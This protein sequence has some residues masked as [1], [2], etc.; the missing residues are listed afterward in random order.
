[1][2]ITK[3][4]KA[5]GH[6]SFNLLNMVISIIQYVQKKI[7][8]S[9]FSTFRKGGAKTTFKKRSEGTGV[10]E[11]NSADSVALLKSRFTSTLLLRKVEPN[12]V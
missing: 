8:L 12:L 4:T 3:Y 11:P 10:A 7:C 2:E 6:K 9:T 5:G 1:M